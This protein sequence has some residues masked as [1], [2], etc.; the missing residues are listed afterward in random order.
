MLEYYYISTSTYSRMAESIEEAQ[1]KSPKPRVH[2]FC[3]HEVFARRASISP[4]ALA[5]VDGPD[6]LTYKQLNDRA[7]HLANY[8]R[9][10]GIGPGAYVGIFADRSLEM[11]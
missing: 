8:L 4:N 2:D 10:T 6:F 11:V 9:S 7:D 5:L 3:V 1:V